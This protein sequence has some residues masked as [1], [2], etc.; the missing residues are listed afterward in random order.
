[1]RPSMKLSALRFPAV[2]AAALL[3]TVGCRVMNHEETAGQYVD[4]STLSARA[5]AALIKDNNVKSSDFSI[6]VYQG[7][8][9]LTGVAQTP[10]ESKLAEQDIRAIDGVKSVKNDVRIA[11]ASDAVSK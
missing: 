3:A 7:N 8:V 5:K 9:T 11:N 10:T 1:M 4:D 6:E 2:A